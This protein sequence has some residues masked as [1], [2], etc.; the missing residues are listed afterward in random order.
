MYRV[1]VGRSE[2]TNARK[3]ALSMF[4]RFTDRARRVVVLAQEEARM[5]NHDYI[6]SEHILLALIHEESGVAAQALESLGIAEGAARQQ[7]EEITGRG[8]QDPPRGHIPFTPRAKKILQLSMREAIALGHAYI[9]TEHILLGLVR[10]DDG[11][12]VRVLNGLGADPNRVRQQVIQRVHA[13]RVQEEPGTGR[14]T[15]RGKRKVLS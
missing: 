2:E 1:S 13:R 3:A 8:Q 10:E 15:G 4:E 14:P 11:V 5:L 9:G 6:G 7:V 12:A